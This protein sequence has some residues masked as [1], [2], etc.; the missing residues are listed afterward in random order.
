MATFTSLPAAFF[1][2]EC[3]LERREQSVPTLRSLYSLETEMA[4]AVVD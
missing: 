4:L 2:G 1:F 3:L